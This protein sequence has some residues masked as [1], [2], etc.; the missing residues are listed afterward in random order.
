MAA[1]HSQAMPA[2]LGD[3]T[4]NVRYQ[5][6]SSQVQLAQLC[7]HV[8]PQR[9]A[10]AAQLHLHCDS[11]AVILLNTLLF[12][13]GDLNSFKNFASLI[14]KQITQSTKH[15]FVTKFH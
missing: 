12:L 2:A 6:Q 10:A 8:R 5:E 1:G 11:R 3:S 13:Q 4:P 9:W 14:R 7:L 15:I